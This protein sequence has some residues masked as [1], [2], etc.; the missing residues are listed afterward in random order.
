M[1]EAAPQLSSDIRPFVRE[2]RPLLQELLP[3]A[4]DFVHSEP[5]LT[6]SLTVLNHLFN[7]FGYNPKG[8]EAPGV[9]GTRRGLRVRP[10]VAGSPVGQPVL[11]RRRQR[12]DAQHH[13]GRS[14]QRV[15]VVGRAPFPP[16]E[17]I[18]GLTGVLTDP[19]IC[20]GE[21]AAARQATAKKQF[22]GKKAQ[23]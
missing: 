15:R 22:G 10:R 21:G 19:R 1:K 2:A 5:L 9:A 12:P 16:A 11:H 6:R 4:D 8:R 14:L 7:M 13:A 20:G 18:L 23:G 17:F 3:A